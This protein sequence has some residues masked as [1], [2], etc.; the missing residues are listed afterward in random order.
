MTW[1]IPALVLAPAHAGVPV[2]R[3]VGV[4]GGGGD[5]EGGLPLS[6]GWLKNIWMI[7][8]VLA[9]DMDFLQK[10]H[11]TKGRISFSLILP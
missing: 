10:Q 11:R 6:G 4:D 2:L 8:I 5:E 9:L 1:G 3:D 7:K